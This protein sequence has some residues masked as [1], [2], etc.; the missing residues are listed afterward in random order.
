MPYA[1]VDPGE[2]W[3]QL[4]F[5]T[6]PSWRGQPIRLVA[7]D[8]A[9]VF[10]GWL[11]VSLPFKHPA[12]LPT[13]HTWRSTAIIATAYLLDFAVLFLP[14]LAFATL[15]SRQERFP[16]SAVPALALIGTSCAGLLAFFAFFIDRRIGMIFDIA[17][18]LFA[19]FI[20]T[21]PTHRRILAKPGVW[22]PVFLTFGFG[23]VTI[24]ILLFG[25]PPS[26]DPTWIGLTRFFALRPP[27]SVI[28]AALADRI[29]THSGMHA[30]MFGYL[31]SDRPPL[32]SGLILLTRPFMPL[33]DAQSNA[34]VVGIIAQ[35]TW[36]IG[37]LFLLWAMN[38]AWEPFVGC[39]R[40]RCSA[41][42]RALQRY[43]RLAENVGC[44]SRARRVCLDL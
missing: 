24:G 41:R 30:D 17:I 35:T 14:G 6:P 33:L 19:L 39:H 42:L 38:V 10:Q 29:F 16:F 37:A 31:G 18:T 22:K 26:T 40:T 12:F 20:L 43:L 23:L 32:Q 25:A 2:Q 36:V 34:Y 44:S 1:G 3:Q 13:F 28:P 15:A 9:I 27:D 8:G 11:G 7:I 21:R 4:A 5:A